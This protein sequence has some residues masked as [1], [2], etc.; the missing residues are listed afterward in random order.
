MR[1]A[2]LIAAATLSATATRAEPATHVFTEDKAA[3]QA[4]ADMFWCEGRERPPQRYTDEMRELRRVDAGVR[5]KFTYEAPR[6]GKDVWA[7]SNAAMERGETFKGDCDDLAMTTADYLAW[8]G[9][10]ADRLYRVVMTVGNVKHMVAMAVDST[11]Q[12]WV[13]GDVN[14]ALYKAED[15]DWLYGARQKV[16]YLN[17]IDEGIVWRRP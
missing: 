10:P 14:G 9:W 13:V 5:A 16:L 12:R 7:S 17:R 3:C 11:G 8:D 1:L 2:I 4:N 6:G 15:M